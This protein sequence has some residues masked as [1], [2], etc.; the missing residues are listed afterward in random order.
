MCCVVVS[1]EVKEEAAAAAAEEEEAEATSLQLLREYV[2][3]ARGL[4]YKCGL[5]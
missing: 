1:V 5:I 4:K 3:G 2:A